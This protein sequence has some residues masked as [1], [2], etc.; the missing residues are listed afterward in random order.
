MTAIGPIRLDRWHGRCPRC[1]QVGFAADGLLG[2]GGWLTARARRMACLAGLHDPFRKAEQLLAELAG[3]SIA[4]ETLRRRGHAEAAA[5]ARGRA[6]RTAL[7]EAFAAAPPEREL[8]IDAGKVNT[9]EGWRDV[10]VAVFAGREVAPA[11]SAADYEQ[12]ELP[13]PA[14]RS[15]VAAVA[16]AEAFGERCLAEAQRLGLTQ[17]QRLSV[18]G[19]GAEWIWNL[20]EQRFAGAAQVL[21]VYHAVEHLAAV[22]RQALG[23]GEALGPWLEAARRQLLGDGY[24]GVCA[25]LGR[26]PDEPA[27]AERLAAAAGS[28]LNYF[29]GHRER[30]GYALRLRRGQVIGSG[31]VEGTIKEQVN[32]RLKRTGARWQAAR[33]GP[34]VELLALSD[35]PEWNE[36]W[37]ALAV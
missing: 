3:W 22:G 35:S 1:R 17:E 2:I 15:V 16:P 4:A 10:K 24:A 31:L 28:A 19:D 5:A 37:A 27:A 21:D 36:Y 20:A 11:A 32:L 7:P 30:L 9:P 13:A 26:P 12:R 23:E 6:E 18:L 25:V 29:C 33:V 8:H 14:V 34:F